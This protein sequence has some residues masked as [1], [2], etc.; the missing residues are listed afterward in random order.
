M[1]EIS[2]GSTV[3]E[4]D[5]RLW[6]ELT[7]EQYGL[8]RELVR[9]ETDE[10]ILGLLDETERVIAGL[11]AHLPGLAPAIRVIAEHLVESGAIYEEGPP[12]RPCCDRGRREDDAGPQQ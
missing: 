11:E 5:R 4:I 6:L 10:P 3:R 8:V 2:N 12:G 9:L 1:H 7:P